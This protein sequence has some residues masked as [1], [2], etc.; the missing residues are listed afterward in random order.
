MNTIIKASEFYKL[1]TKQDVYKAFRHIVSN[2]I[3]L[4]PAT[5]YEVKMHDQLFPPKDFLRIIAQQKG[6]KILEK[7][8][9]GL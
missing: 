5:K 1:I 7:K 9:D 2:D 6:Y 8:K 4:I 3:D